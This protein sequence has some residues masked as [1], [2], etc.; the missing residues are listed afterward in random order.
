MNNISDH[1]AN[2]RTFLAW[3]RTAIGIMALGFAMVKFSLFVKQISLALN[4]PAT[5]GKG[6]SSLAGI[7]L[8]IAGALLTIFAFVRY[9]RTERLIN[10]QHPTQDSR[11]LT[12]L[13]VFIFFMGLSL[14]AYLV[15]TY[16]S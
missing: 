12:A 11:L 8:V 7:I 9:K 5:T 15:F 1:L 16:R 13:T 6:Y 2:E 10:Q 14:M 4:E 3:I